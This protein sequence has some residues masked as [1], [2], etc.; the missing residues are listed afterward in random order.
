MEKI[1]QLTVVVAVVADADLFFFQALLP[2]DPIMY[3]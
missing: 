3:P 1:D 2:T